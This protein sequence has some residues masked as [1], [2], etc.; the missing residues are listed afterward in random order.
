MGL[1]SGLFRSDPQAE[2]L[3]A[4]RAAPEGPLR[5]YLAQPFPD[6]TTPVEELPLLALDVETTGLDPRKD[7]V[8]SVGFV[9]LDGL[10]IDLSGARRLLLAG[11]H[12][13]GQ[14]ATVHRITDD[15]LAAYGV[16]PLEALTATLE[17]LT[18]R[19]IL[20]HYAVIETGFLDAIARRV[21]GAGAPS[22]AIDTLELQR[23]LTTTW[24]KEPLVG[25]LRLWPARERWGLPSYQAHEAL[26][27]ALACAELYLAQVSRLREEGPVTLDSLR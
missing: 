23:R 15:D 10:R 5:D 20:A 12:E 16:P 13:V 8:L 11:A 7:H 3:K 9:P 25:T 1:F 21:F 2:R 6:G 27:D 17:A 18:G 24:N 26:I 14:S 22:I 4:L 19:V